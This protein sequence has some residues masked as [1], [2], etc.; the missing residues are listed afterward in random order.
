M[1]WLR[2][3]SIRYKILLIVLIAVLGFSVNLVFNYSVTSSNAVRLHHIKDVYFPTLERIDANLVR[4]D[5]IKE[6]MNTAA[7]TAELDML[8]DTDELA[9]AMHNAFAEVSQLDAG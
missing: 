4:L 1:N 6:T 9:E 8:E 3:L 5:Q 7:S 2:S